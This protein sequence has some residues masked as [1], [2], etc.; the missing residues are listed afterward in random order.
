[1]IQSHNPP[2]QGAKLDPEGRGGD[3]TDEEGTPW[4]QRMHVNWND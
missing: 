3:C 4:E 2:H 1:M